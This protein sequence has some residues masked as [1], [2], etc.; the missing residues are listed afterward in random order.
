[1]QSTSMMTYFNFL[2]PEKR[3]EKYFLSLHNSNNGLVIAKSK[4]NFFFL[5]IFGH[6]TQQ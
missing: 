3:G 6:S 5:S 2:L 4:K 1:M